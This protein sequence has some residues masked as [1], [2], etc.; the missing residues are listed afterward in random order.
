MKKITI[1]IL[2]AML[3]LGLVSTASAAAPAPGGP[4]STAFYIQNLEATA[5]TCQYS[6]YNATGVEVLTSTPFTVQGG[7]NMEIFTPSLTVSAGAYSAVVS[8]DKEVAAVV[9]FSDPNSGASHNGIAAPAGTWFAPNIYD[10]YYGY[11][12]NVYAQNATS[13]ALDITL[14]IYKAGQVAP[15]YSNTKSA[16]P[17]YSSV[18]WE[19]EGLTE[20]DNNASY[21]AKIYSTGN[22]AS[23]VNVY[24]AASKG[25]Q[26]YSYNPFTAGADVVYVPMLY[27]NYYGFNTELKIQ[28]VD[29]ADAIVHI[30]YSNGTTKDV[31]IAPNSGVA[32]YTPGVLPVSWSSP[33]SAVVTSTNSKKIVVVVNQS[34]AVGAASTYNGLDAGSETVFTPVL[35]NKYY[36]FNTEVTCQNVGGA[37]TDITITYNNTGL[38]TA[39]TNT[40]TGV[41]AG[42]TAKFYTPSHVTVNTYKGSGVIT[43]TG[44]VP[45]ACVVNE[46]SSDTSHLWDSQ[47]TY[48]GVMK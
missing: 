33:Y 12:T 29:T 47:Y 31:T 28:N 10:N 4:F 22:I 16:V 9:N 38:P 25:I 17:A 35:Y 3:T 26:L 46:G 27:N 44:S 40:V 42:K 24:D 5:A 6:F 41:A 36:T 32:Y 39:P 21:S 13:A 8:C 23:V 43:S 11:Y 20:L 48:N 34:N 2:I 7:S 15:V 37:S 1:L 19:Q 14:E 30:E 18:V 45:I